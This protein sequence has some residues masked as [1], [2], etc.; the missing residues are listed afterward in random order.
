MTPIPISGP[1][2]EPV[3]LAA[4]RAYLRVDHVAEDDL[5]AGLVRAA[6]LLVEAASRRIL[7]EQTWRVVLDRW[8]ESRVVNL[9]V[10]P[11]IAV[12]RIR[13]ATGPAVAVDLPVSSYSADAAADP[14][15]VAIGAG[16]PEPGV[17]AGGIAIDLRAG[18]GA[19]PEAVPEPMRLAVQRQV[20]R[21]F[22]NRGD[23]AGEQS[24]PP[25]DLALLA[26]YRRIRL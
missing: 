9:P 8:P 23:V 4:M 20:A 5:I 24:L 7:V 12:D 17:P 15:R 19:A 14:P 1:A 13:V 11:L 10:S 18:Y 26:P 3:T 2:V 6:R 16:V 25:E 21:W 22:E